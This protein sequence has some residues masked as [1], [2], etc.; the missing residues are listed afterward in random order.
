LRGFICMRGVAATNVGDS[1]NDLSR[2]AQTS[3]TL[4]SGGLVGDHQKT[5]ASAMGLQRVLG[6]RS[7][8]TAWTGCTNCE[9]QVR[10]G[11]DRLSGRVEVDETYLGGLRKAFVPPRL[12]AKR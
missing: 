1:R 7:Y 2:H 8:K 3:E 10:P 9:R 6:L 5:G 11:R 4:V 12:R